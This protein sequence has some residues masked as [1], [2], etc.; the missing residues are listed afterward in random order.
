[1]GK[2]FQ[3]IFDDIQEGIWFQGL[4]DDFKESE[5]ISIAEGRKAYPE[6]EKTLKYDRPDIILADNGVPILVIERTVEVPSGHNVGQ[7]FGRIAAAA[8]EGIPS[9]YLFP[10][11]AF[12]HGGA[13]KGPRY[14]NLR[15]FNAFEIMEN[16]L[17]GAITTINWPVD[18]GYEVIKSPEKD[19]RIKEY[20][21]LFLELYYDKVP[22]INE[23]IKNSGFHKREIS[24]R[25]IFALTKVKRKK[26]YDGPPSSVNIVPVERLHKSPLARKYGLKFN[27]DISKFDE[28]VIYKI[29]MTYVR[30][31]PYTG[32]AMLYRH[33]YIEG[34]DECKRGLYLL[35]PDIS[36][37]DWKA[38]DENRKDV[39]LYSEVADGILLKD[40]YISFINY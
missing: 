2:N 23:A 5:L 36:I 40:G 7:R 16:E 37:A 8:E 27:E 31:D 15:L 29:G 33:L 24:E 12:K 22:D 4:N 34:Y 10:Y 26:V 39:R 13:T 17:E 21:N 32:T 11:V 25:N 35:I 28:L 18:Q 3:I 19:V 6:I 14:V 1:M 9:I 30:S 38:V 20:L